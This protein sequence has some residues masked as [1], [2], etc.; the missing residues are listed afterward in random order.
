MN[1]VML[2]Q[3]DENSFV[4][5][6]VPADGDPVYYRFDMKTEKTTQIP[7]SEV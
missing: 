6:E 5:V 1:S 4:Y 2:E 7:E 3:V